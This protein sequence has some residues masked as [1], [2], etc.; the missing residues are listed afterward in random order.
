MNYAITV[1]EE[2]LKI[3]NSAYSQYVEFG[4]V[5]KDNKTAIS[6]DAKIKGLEKAIELLKQNDN[7]KTITSTIESA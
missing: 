2:K 3:L 7:E 5:A 1:L 6:M 4:T